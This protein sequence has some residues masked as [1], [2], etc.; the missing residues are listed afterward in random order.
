MSALS[1]PQLQLADRIRISRI[2]AFPSEPAVRSPH[3]LRRFVAPPASYAQS[4]KEITFRS[5]HCHQGAIKY[6]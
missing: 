2:G 1:A 3:R 5:L 6:C 4:L